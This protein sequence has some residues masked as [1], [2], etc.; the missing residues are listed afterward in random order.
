MLL[1]P[2]GVAIH[3]L[4]LG[5]A[6]GGMSAGVFGCGP[7]GL[8]LVQALRAIGC[9]PIVATDPLPHRRAAATASGAD[10]VAEP[11][12]ADLPV[13]DVAFEVA[14]EDA[15]IADAVDHVRPGGRVVLAG[16]PDL[17]RVVVPAAAARRKGLS[18][19]FVRR[20]APTD[21]A[22][23]LRMAEWASSRFGR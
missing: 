19:L 4:D 17:D 5:K 23:A 18:M 13:V 3:A 10:V 7:I 11:G 20:M 21:L 2:L 14:G 12:A 22:R 8:L 16:I 6:R 9:R 1:E 15:A